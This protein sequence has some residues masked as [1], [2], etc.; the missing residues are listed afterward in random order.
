MSVA[1]ELRQVLQDFLAPELREIKAHLDS[2]DKRFDNQDKRLDT[3]EKGYDVR[4]QALAQR[5]D[6][7]EKWQ[8]CPVPGNYPTPGTNSAVFRLRQTYFQSRSRK[9]A[10]RLIV[11]VPGKQK[12]HSVL[13][14]SVNH[15]VLLI[16]ASTPTAR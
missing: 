14:H 16:Q 12:L 4:Y 13:L 8:C 7:T 2:I 15:T 9:V 10:I 5:L 11:M 1:E 6:G 3:I